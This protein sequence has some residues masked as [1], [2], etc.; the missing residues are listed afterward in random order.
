MAKVSIKWLEQKRFVGIDANNHTVVIGGS[1]DQKIGIRPV[2]L[3]LFALGSCMGYDVVHVLERKRQKL[4]DFEVTV[5]GDMLPDAPWTFTDFHLKFRVW[6]SELSEKAVQD[7]IRIA[8]DQLC[9][10]FDLLR[11]G[12]SITKEYEILG[13]KD[14][15]PAKS[16]SEKSMID[17]AIRKSEL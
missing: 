11:K 5:T 17:R 3:L 4:E 1:G 9:G 2:D 12:A 15:L 10:V 7:A 16:Y 6:G 13:S 14:R 8:S